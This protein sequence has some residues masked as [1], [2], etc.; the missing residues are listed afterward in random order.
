M[1][2]EELV[3]LVV[4]LVVINRYLVVV[5]DDRLSAGLHR[6]AATGSQQEP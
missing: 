1:V 2:T 6:A 5:G 4:L 3:Q